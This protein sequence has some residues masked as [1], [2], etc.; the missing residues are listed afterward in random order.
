M[1]IY[2]HILVGLD[3]SKESHTVLEK[4]VELAKFC[5]A[6]ISLIHIV[7]PLAFAYTGD[8]PINLMDTEQ[9]LLGHAKTQLDDFATALPHPPEFCDVVLGSTAY[10][11]HKKAE[12]LAADLLV[13]GSHGRHGLA[14]IMGSTASDVIHGAKRDVL[15]VR[16]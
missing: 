5:D 1:T 6:K 16:I 14:L 9:A 12:E 13:V 15:A 10:E 8:L 11:I 3:L 7:E 4:A 2:S